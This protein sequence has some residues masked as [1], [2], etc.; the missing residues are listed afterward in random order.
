M[1][2]NNAILIIDEIQN[3]VSS[4]GTYYKELYDLI[5]QSSKDT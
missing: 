4:T 3:M 5:Y 1:K 2:L